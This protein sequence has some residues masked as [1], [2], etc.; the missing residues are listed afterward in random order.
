MIF[1]DAELSFSLLPDS[2]VA[3][4]LDDAT[5]GRSWK[6]KV[7]GD[8]PMSW[9]S[10]EVYILTPAGLH[11]RVLCPTRHASQV[12]EGQPEIH[13]EVGNIENGAPERRSLGVSTIPMQACSAC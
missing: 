6:I 8:H 9:T 13:T 11:C 5:S 3:V 10:Q 12:Q 1:R 7:E 4:H 2:A